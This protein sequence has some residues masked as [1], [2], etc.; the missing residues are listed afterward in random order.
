MSV[1]VTDLTDCERSHDET[2]EITACGSKKGS[3]ARFS[4]SEDWKP[5]SAQQ[6]VD[7]LAEGP[8]RWSQYSSGQVCE[9]S[10]ER[11]GNRIERKEYEGSDRSQNAEG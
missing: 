8:E 2:K 9:Q 10:L 1:Q 7:H 3:E 11:H 5:D 6:D 4:A